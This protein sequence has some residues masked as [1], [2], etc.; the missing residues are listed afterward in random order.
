VAAAV[1]AVLAAAAL[2]ATA[3]PPPAP[4][5]RVDTLII[6][7]FAPRPSTPVTAA[8]ADGASTVSAPAPVLSGFPALPPLTT[9]DGIAPVDS[10]PGGFRPSLP[11]GPV[12]LG[13]LLGPARPLAGILDAADEGVDAPRLLTAGAS[14][15]AGSG[16]R[17]VVELQFV[18]DT[19]G[20]V[21]PGSIAVTQAPDSTLAAAAAAIVRAARFEPGRAAGRPVGIRVRQNVTFD[22]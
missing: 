7:H 17:G 5:F 10:A 19:S 14:P 2:R 12:D 4:G 9:P 20:H 16:V 3:A 1:H 22:P 15:L 8:R 11:G 21:E 13:G 18:V 6:E